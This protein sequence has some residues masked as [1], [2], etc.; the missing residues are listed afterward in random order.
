M[1][2]LE[3]VSSVRGHYRT[4]PYHNFRHAFDVTQTCYVY[5]KKGIM[6]R[7]LVS[8]LDVFALMVSALCHDIQ[9]PGLTNSFQCSARTKLSLTYNDI[10]VLENMHASV[11]FHLL[12]G[13]NNDVKSGLLGKIEWLLP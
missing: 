7:Q 5:L 12:L 11:T 10:S 9:H 1:A 3:F 2:L 13:P 6:G 8:S 4:N